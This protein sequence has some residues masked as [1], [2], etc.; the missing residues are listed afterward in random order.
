MLKRKKKHTRTCFS[1]LLPFAGVK[2]KRQLKDSKLRA[3]LVRAFQNKSFANT[4]G[5]GGQLPQCRAGRQIA[6]VGLVHLQEDVF[7][8]DVCVDDLAFSVQVI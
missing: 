8:L 7:G 5:L 4:A 1:L 3:S 2:T 6:N